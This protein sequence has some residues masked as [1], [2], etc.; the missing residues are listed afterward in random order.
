MT[1]ADQCADLTPTRAKSADARRSA[2]ETGRCLGIGGRSFD[3]CLVPFDRGRLMNDPLGTPRTSPP[4]PPQE[5]VPSLPKSLPNSGEHVRGQTRLNFPTTIRSVAA[6][7]FLH[8]QSLYIF[9][10]FFI[11]GINERPCDGGLLLGGQLR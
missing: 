6:F 10:R 11:Q 1:G 3:G 8:P 2:R 5:S 4:P 9:V 7:R